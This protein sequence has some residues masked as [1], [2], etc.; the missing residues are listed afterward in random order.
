MSSTGT[1]DAR[2]DELRKM[3]G[4]GK[5]TSA[6]LVDQVYAHRI[7][8]ELA[9]R[10]PRGGTAKYLERPLMEHYRDYIED[11][12][13]TVLDDGGQAAMKRSAEHL[14]DEV[15]ITA[16]REWGDLLKSGHPSVTQDGRT[17]YDRPPKVH[18]LTKQELKAKSRATMR[19]RLAAGLTVYFMRGGKVMVIPGKNEPHDLRGRL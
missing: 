15:E 19:A 18:R 14:S 9:W 2:I 6:V 11:Y 16:P 13:K 1:F 17:I 8:E 4:S 12:A 5:I 10:H 7:H 3:V